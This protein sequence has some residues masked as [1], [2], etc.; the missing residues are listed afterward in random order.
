MDVTPPFCHKLL[1]VPWLVSEGGIKT[2]PVN[3]LLEKGNLVSLKI[4]FETAKKA[5]S[6]IVQL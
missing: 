6:Y 1:A 5:M 2:L 3:N 4:P